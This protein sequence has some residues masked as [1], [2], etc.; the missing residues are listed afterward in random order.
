MLAYKIRNM[1]AIITFEKQ[2]SLTTD[3]SLDFI[4]RPVLYKENTTFREPGLLPSSGERYLQ[5]LVR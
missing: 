3:N 2:S 5:R 4:P 1:K